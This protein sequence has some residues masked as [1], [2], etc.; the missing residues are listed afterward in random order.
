M[1]MKEN[2]RSYIWNKNNTIICRSGM[3]SLEEALRIVLER[4]PNTS[5]C[6]EYDNAYYFGSTDDENCESGYG[7]TPRVVLK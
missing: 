3:V 1:I 6:A 4:N 7:H 2:K 5:I